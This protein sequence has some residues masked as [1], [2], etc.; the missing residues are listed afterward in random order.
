MTDDEIKTELKTL[1]LVKSPFAE[2]ELK[3]GIIN[4][5]IT[6]AFSMLNRLRPKI[7]K[8]YAPND[9]PNYT[10]IRAYSNNFDM[11]TQIPYIDEFPTEL[12]AQYIYSTT[13]DL[14]G[15]WDNR[16]ASKHFKDLVL[17]YSIQFMSNRRRMA[18]MGGLPFNLKGDDFYSKAED[19][20]AKIE[21]LLTNTTPNTY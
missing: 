13:W 7:V 12:A 16:I 8:L 4:Q 21:E 19:E 2:S 9:N 10:L 1:V 5:A 17:Q 11:T 6:D 14:Q 15:V 3:D 20:I 18:D